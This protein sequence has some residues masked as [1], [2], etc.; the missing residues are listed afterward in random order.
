MRKN[1]KDERKNDKGRKVMGKN[2]KGWRV[3][4]KID[5][6]RRVM[7]KID[8]EW[9]VIGSRNKF[10]QKKIKNLLG[11]VGLFD[12]LIKIEIKNYKYYAILF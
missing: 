4:G 10:F 8:K 1:N 7:G 11:E 6:G 2:D 12:L 3:M 5:K 9:R